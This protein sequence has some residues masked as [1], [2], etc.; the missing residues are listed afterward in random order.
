MDRGGGGSSTRVNQLMAF[1]V[2]GGRL[3]P[4]MPTGPAV[5]TRLVVHDA[6][7]LDDSDIHAHASGPRHD[8]SATGNCTLVQVGWL[9]QG[10]WPNAAATVEQVTP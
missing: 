8:M 9:V 3:I 10:A 2:F 6:T 4:T 7:R 5:C 1:D